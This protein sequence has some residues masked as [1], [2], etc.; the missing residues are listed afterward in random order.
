MR[1][2]KLY[3]DQRKKLMK[4][5]NYVKKNLPSFLIKHD[6]SLPIFIC[7]DEVAEEAFF[8]KKIVISSF[9]YPDPTSKKINRVVVNA[10]HTKKDLQK[11]C[12]PASLQY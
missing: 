6:S 7:K 12:F 5:I 1:S 11:L 3:T 4:N 9:G 8:E 2:K 10:L